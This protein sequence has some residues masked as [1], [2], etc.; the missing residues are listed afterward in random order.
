[1]RLV[2]DRQVARL[3]GIS[4]ETLRKYVTNRLPFPKGSDVNLDNIRRFKIGA[5]RRWVRDDCVKEA[6]RVGV[7]LPP[8]F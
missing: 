3:F 7:P 2:K 8:N 5:Q 6:Q 4:V 1:M